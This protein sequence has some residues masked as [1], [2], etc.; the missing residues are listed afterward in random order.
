M[1]D[2]G[3][4]GGQVGGEGSDRSGRLPGGRDVEQGLEGYRRTKAFHSKL[5]QGR[6][7]GSFSCVLSGSLGLAEHLFEWMVKV[8]RPSQLGR[9]EGQTLTWG[10]GERLGLESCYA[11][12][13]RW[14]LGQGPCPI[15]LSPLYS[16][17]TQRAGLCVAAV[18]KYE[19][20]AG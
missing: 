6:A 17:C 1:L 3:W 19:P 5:L 20:F 16:V 2:Y 14:A 13:T 12:H 9:S 18:L 11:T 8:G 4:A 10:A 15:S 7:Y